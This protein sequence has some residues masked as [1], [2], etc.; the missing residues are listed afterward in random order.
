[1]KI[2]AQLLGGIFDWTPW[3]NGKQQPM[4]HL[5]NLRASKLNLL[6]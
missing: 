1:M 2:E 3:V 4:E 6:N 5:P